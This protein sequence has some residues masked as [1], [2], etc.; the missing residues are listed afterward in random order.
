VD[1]VTCGSSAEAIRPSQKRFF[2]A[3]EVAVTY[4]ANKLPVPPRLAPPGDARVTVIRREP[5]LLQLQADLPLDLPGF[6]VVSQADLPGWHARV[7]GSEV[8]IHRTYGVIQGIVVPG[9][10]H[11][12]LLQYSPLSFKLG[13]A[14]SLLAAVLLGAAALRERRLRRGSEQWGGLR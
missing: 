11:R 2:D 12:I 3:E 10:Q 9:G 4:C 8:P 14:F 6:L 13:I 7:D 5:G 1:R